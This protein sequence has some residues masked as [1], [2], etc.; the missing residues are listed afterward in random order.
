MGRYKS[1]YTSPDLGY[2]SNYLTYNPPIKIPMN[3]QAG[4][5]RNTLPQEEILTEPGTHRGSS[6]S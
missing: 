4:F 3:L 6:P 1:G 5:I 2:N